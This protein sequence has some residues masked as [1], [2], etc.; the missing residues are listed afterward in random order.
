MPWSYLLSM[1]F[2]HASF[3]WLGLLGSALI[4]LGAIMVTLKAKNPSSPQTSS[5][6]V[7]VAE[8]HEGEASDQTT[9]EAT[10]IMHEG[11]V[12]IMESRELQPGN[13]GAQSNCSVHDG[14]SVGIS[15]E[16][17]ERLVNITSSDAEPG[18]PAPGCQA[19]HETEKTPF[20]PKLS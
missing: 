18:D 14:A 12:A 10:V 4:A 1:V 2:L 3:T 15:R 9:A 17:Q 16:H 5:E 19:P 11:E 13:K 6:G 7:Q 20:L 8:H